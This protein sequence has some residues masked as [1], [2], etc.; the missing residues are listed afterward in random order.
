LLANGFEFKGYIDK[1]GKKPDI[2]CV[3]ETWLKN[4]LDFIIKGYNTVMK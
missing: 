4:N 1:L 3:Q 2:I